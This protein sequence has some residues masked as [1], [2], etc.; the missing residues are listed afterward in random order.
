MTHSIPTRFANPTRRWFSGSSVGPCTLSTLIQTFSEGGMQVHSPNLTFTFSPVFRFCTAGS[1]SQE[2]CFAVV[3]SRVINLSSI[4]APVEHDRSSDHAK[5]NLSSSPSPHPKK[6]QQPSPLGI[7]EASL[8]LQVVYQPQTP[9]PLDIVFVHGLGGH[10]R[11]TW[12]KHHDVTRFWPGIWLPDDPEVG[13]ARI[14]TFGY[15]A[16]FSSAQKGMT[17]I[18]NFAKE[19]LN[20]MRRGRSEKGE[21]LELGRVPIIFVVHSM[22]GLVVKKAYLLGQN[23]EEYREIVHSIS[24]IVFLSTPH[25]GTDL[26]EILN[27]ILMVSFRTPKGYVQDLARNSTAIEEV[28]E[29]FRHIAPKL[30]ITSFYETLATAIGPTNIMILEGDSSVM[31][32]PQEVS[33]PLLADHHSVCKYSSPQE[34]NY[35]KVLNTLKDF[36]GRLQVAKTKRTGSHALDEIKTIQKL[37][38]VTSN[39][40]LDLE[41]F[42]KTRTPGTCEWLF[43]E[44]E[45]ISWM[46]PT[47][48]C[49]VVWLSAQPACGKSILCTY[50]IDQ[51]RQSRKLCQ[52]F[53]FRFNHQEK[54]SLS[55]LLR[56]LALQIARDVPNFKRTLVELSSEG[57]RL[58][59]ADASLIWR[60]V[61]EERLFRMDLDYP[62]YWVIDAL[63]ESD[64]PRALLDL[65]RSLSNIDSEMS[66]RICIVSRKVEALTLAFD[67][68]A[69][70]VPLSRVEKAGSD[71][72][73]DDIRLLVD[74]EL[75][76]MRGSSD[77]R[78]KVKQK[79]MSRAEGNFLWARL[80]VEDIQR[81]H[82]EEAIHE[83][84]D[85][86]P[87]ELSRLYQRME[88]TLL[89]GLRKSD[90]CLARALLQWTICSRRPLHLSELSQALRPGLPEFLDLQSSISDLCGQFVQVDPTGHVGLVHQTAREYFTQITTSELSVNPK[91]AHGQLFTKSIHTLADP[92]LR[93][94]LTQT[95]DTF[96]DKEPFLCY[97]AV[98]WAHHLQRSDKRDEYLDMLVK[99]FEGPSVLWW[100]HTL[101]LIDKAEIL[102]KT[103]KILSSF[104]PMLHRLSDLE[105]LDQ[106]TIDLIKIMGKFSG[107]LQADPRA[108]YKLSL[109]HRQF[110][111]PASAELTVS[112]IAN[113][114]WDDNLARINL[115]R[116]ASA[117][118]IVCA[119]DYIAKFSEIATISHGEPKGTRMLWSLPDMICQSLVFAD[120]DSKIIT[121]SRDRTA[122]ESGWQILHPDLL[123]DSDLGEGAILNSPKHMA[124]NGD[125][126]Q[127]A[128]SYRSFPL[129][130]WSLSDA[131]C[132]R[133]N[134][135][136][137]ATWF[138]VDR[139][140]WNPVTGHI[141]G[142]YKD[143]RIFKWHPLTDESQ[144][145]RS[146]AGEIAA[147]SNG[148]LFATSNSN[149]TVT[150]W[151]FAYFSVI[152]Q[153]A[154]DDLVT[155]LT[156]SPDCTR[157]YDLRSNTVNAWESNS[158]LRFSEAEE[159]VSDTASEQQSS[160]CISKVSEAYQEQFD[161]ISTLAVA[162][163]GEY[164]CAGDENGT[165]TLYG[166]QS[167]ESVELSELSSGD[168]EAHLK[169]SD[170]CQHIAAYLDGRITILRIELESGKQGLNKAGRAVVASHAIE[171]LTWRGM[172]ELLLSPDS[173]SLLIVSE[174]NCHILF[175]DDGS[176]GTSRKWLNHPSRH[177]LLLS[178][179]PQDVRVFRWDDLAEDNRLQIH[180]APPQNQGNADLESQARHDPKMA[181]LPS[182]PADEDGEKVA[183]VKALLT[184][185]GKHVLVQVNIGPI[186]GALDRRVL[187]FDSSSFDPQ[188]QA[189]ATGSLPYLS[190]PQSLSRNLEACLGVLSGLGSRLV[191]LDQELWICTYDLLS[192]SDDGVEYENALQRHFFVPRDWMSGRGLELCALMEDGALLCPK[193]DRVA[194]IRGGLR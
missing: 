66:I 183:V 1:A 17:N 113:D 165:V 87:G 132:N 39:P 3:L 191:F 129:S 86:I 169:W 18:T 90:R 138:P 27:R 92:A 102:I 44:P 177:D 147:S 146:S 2:Y 163:R 156:F 153:L 175:V 145:V 61:F 31:G 184:P 82:T 158:L 111:D 122:F 131:N 154:S 78:E 41:A 42:R 75:S 162:P 11:K 88:A 12:S 33:I 74:Q 170:D 161:A 171:D 136:K 47:P 181:P 56:S 99:L 144:E 194:V 8:G 19:L 57:F 117:K 101:Y 104:N 29:Q 100:I 62:L 43:D 84:L 187:L 40:D 168:G 25:R 55:D 49:Q 134:E 119:G 125:A 109:I 96:M 106:W 71:H 189:Y 76:Y 179:G 182:F 116:T 10:S 70:S 16:N 48:G 152:Y 95:R 20:E 54:R 141:I 133:H 22:G 123:K 103:S 67:R 188:S 120:K 128:V 37:L 72:N 24:G 174:N 6:T 69:K 26:A 185:D 107:P 91:E 14:L 93:L 105:L 58:G 7:D 172:H 180:E 167:G 23:D 151:D 81:C 112:G 142:L 176:R 51:L 166:A 32:Y 98:S 36:I 5:H 52:Y 34:R 186:Y 89:D 160:T 157:F 118:R 173:K 77:L 21:P 63:D 115:S 140:A 97:A 124:F 126:T 85:E 68:L 108:V 164:Y 79:I 28:N 64:S 110:Y 80:V 13:K 65:L 178:M 53:F 15:N 148:K 193:N 73:Y 192:G 159:G 83:A 155:G 45:I 150:I 127:I 4:L 59:K 190:V 50:L 137:P 114:D 143:G 9:A 46:D 60:K 38:S 35:V 130:V 149:G 139:F 94:K 121:A 135:S 30:L